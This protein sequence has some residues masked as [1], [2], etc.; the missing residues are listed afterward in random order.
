MTNETEDALRNAKLHSDR[1]WVDAYYRIVDGELQSV[2]G[3][4]RRKPRRRISATVIAFPNP[5]VT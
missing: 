3:H 1:I 4:W 5:P 2:C